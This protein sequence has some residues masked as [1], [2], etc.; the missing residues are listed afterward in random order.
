MNK[1]A[2]ICGISG[3]DGSWLA[4]LFLSKGYR[5]VG[6]ARD[7]EMSNFENLKRLKIREK[8]DTISMSLVDLRS[9]QKVITEIAPDELYNL[10][11]QSSVGLSFEQPVETL[12]SHALGTLNLLEVIRF[13]K[14]S[15]R[16]YNACSG[17]CFGNMDSKSFADESSA[18]RPKSPYAIA[19]A[20]A[21]WEVVNYRESYDLFA[22]SGILFNHESHLRPEHFVTQK[23]ILAASRIA[24]GS[25]EKLKLGNIKISRDWGWAPDYVDAMWR[26]LQ[27][28]EPE[29]FVIATGKRS[30]LQDFVNEAFSCVRLDWRDHVMVEESLFRPSDIMSSCGLPDK[31]MKRLGWKAKLNMSDVVGEMMKKALMLSLNDYEKI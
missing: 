25:N 22:C 10:A 6:T 27:L 23:I 15:I 2:L 17:E 29:D 28:D 19:K 7:A 30:S 1:V 9:V 24:K 18:F 3:Q 16:F 11:G 21:Y 26:M 13:S 31:A 12:E 20:T 4:K 14:K 5:V 8:V